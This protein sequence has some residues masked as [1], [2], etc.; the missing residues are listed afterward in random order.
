MCLLVS[1]P[2]LYDHP[3]CAMLTSMSVG[4][5][6]ATNEPKVVRN[7][8]IALAIGDIGHV[9]VCYYVLGHEKFFDFARYNAMAY[10]NIVT[11]V[12]SKIDLCRPYADREVCL[13]CYE[14]RLSHWIVWPGQDLE[15]CCV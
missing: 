4:I 12:S 8:V 3:N 13:V 14:D 9:Y 10:G 5:L 7:Y 2:F 6:Y 1:E 11:T 15:V